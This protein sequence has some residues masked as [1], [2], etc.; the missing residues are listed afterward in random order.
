MTRLVFSAT[1]AAGLAFAS[2]AV[3][4][5]PATSGDQQQP[6]TS[7]SDT[8]TNNSDTSNQAGPTETNSN[9]GGITREGNVIDRTGQSTT[10][11]ASSTAPANEQVGAEAQ[12][13]VVTTP[14]YTPA[15]QT[16]AEE[17]PYSTSDAM[18]IG[19]TA[20]GGAGGF[21]NDTLRGATNVGG[22]WDVRL[23]LGTRTPFAA[24]V[25]Y[26]GSAQSIDALGLDQDAML[27]GNGAQGAL[28]LNALPGEA[29]TPFVY[30]GAAW[31]HYNVRHSGPNVSDVANS[32]DVLEVPVGIGV[33]GH[34]NG[35]LVDLR[36]EFRASAFENLT[37]RSGGDDGFVFDA[38]DPNA[39]MNRWGVNASVGYEF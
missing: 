16:N 21:T 7:N 3:A 39:G 30:A 17:Y 2:T 23:T 20:G 14:A 34:V 36:G 29:V 5:S 1:F 19:I 31:R 22:E 28:R 24:E 8:N 27:V 15:A 25:S 18:G 26:I 35:L 11:P 38:A 12:T 33:A 9:S 32:D 37:E 13:T 4:Q 10:D 6:D